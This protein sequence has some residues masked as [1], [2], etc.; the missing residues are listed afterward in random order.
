MPTLRPSSL[1]SRRQAA[2]TADRPAWRYAV[3]GTLLGMG[4]ALSVWAPARWLAWGLHQASQGQVQWL[5]PRGTVWNGSA[6]L[7][8]S[9]GA[10]SLDPQALPGRLHW[11][12]TPTW[13]GA[14]VDWHADCCMAEAAR[15]TLQAGRDSLK[16]QVSDHASVWPAALLTGLGAPWNT[17]QA[18]GQLQLNTRSLQLNWAQGRL[19]VQGQ[20]ELHVQNLSLSL[21]PVKPI[22]SYRIH[23][24]GTPEGTPTPGLLLS[25][26][27]G[28]LM[29]SGQGQWV[30]ERLRFTGEA[31]AQ[32]GHESAFDN[33]LNILGRRQGARSLL[34]LG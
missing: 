5:N 1:A 11:T 3:W 27:Q 12:L 14:R 20:A 4:L 18:D 8:L 26:L 28:P 2:S 33:L 31:S 29:L 22:G 19:Q 10:G 6:Q 34:S 25:T 13:T 15:L 9:A 16:L 23:L 32:E 21:S 24:S 30:G 7:L 17:L